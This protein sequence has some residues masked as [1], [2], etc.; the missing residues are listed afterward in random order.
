MPTHH[1]LEPPTVT[2]NLDTEEM[3]DIT[4]AKFIKYLCPGP[5]FKRKLT[6]PPPDIDTNFYLV[7]KDPYNPAD[8]PFKY[9][10]FNRHKH[11]NPDVLWFQP[12]S[13]NPS[14]LN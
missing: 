11:L 7:G 3:T 1:H 13:K 2:S 12:Y 14:A 6:P 8:P 5:I 4:Y 9:D 10:E